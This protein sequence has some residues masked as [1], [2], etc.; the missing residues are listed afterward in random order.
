MPD[1]AGLVCLVHA[2]NELGTL[3]PIAE[4]R[5]VADGMAAPLH[6]D[7]SQTLGRVDLQEAVRL[8]ETLTLSAHKVGGLRGGSVLIAKAANRLRPLIVGGEQEFGLRPGTTSPALSA[9]TALAVRLAVEEQPARAAAMTTARNAFAACLGVDSST[10]CLTPE[11]ALPNTS[12]YLF[13]VVDGRNLLPALDMAGI[14]ASQGS[15]CSSGSPAPPQV[16]SAIGLSDDDARRCVRFS[17]SHRTSEDDAARAGE[18]VRR[19]VQSL[20][21]PRERSVR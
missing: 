7:A 12:M 14:D 9:A 16:L 18:I 10:R 13:D 5:A 4:A 15:A 1:P 17:F 21:Q 20:Q 19:V 11:Y 8:A 3:Q 6:V 2:Q